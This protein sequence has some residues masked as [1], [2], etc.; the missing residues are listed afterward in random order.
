VTR[1]EEGDRQDRFDAIFQATRRDLLAYALR[2]TRS[3]EDAADALAETYLIAWRKLDSIPRGEEARLWLYGVARNVLRRG[4]AREQALNA[5]V[6][7]L[8]QDIHDGEAIALDAQ[9]ALPPALKAAVRALPERQREVLFLTA[10]EGLTPREIAVVTRTPVNLVRVRLH[11]ARA[12]LRR[13][14]PARTGSQ[15][16][17]SPRSSEP[18]SPRVLTR[19]SGD[20]GS[21]SSPVFAG[22]GVCPRRRRRSTFYGRRFTAPRLLPF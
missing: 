11:R 10:W 1:Q 17:R 4:V 20:R 12:H 8:A 7:R 9:D 19:A 6:E 21:Q 18:R 15:G 5:T 3:P 14:L 16:A 2:R 22:G 13:A